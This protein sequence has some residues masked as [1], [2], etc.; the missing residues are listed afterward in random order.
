MEWQGIETA[1]RDGTPVETGKITPLNQTLGPLYPI[2]SKFMDGKWH[3][4]FGSKDQERW[5]PYDPQ[6]SHWKPLTPPKP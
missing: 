6:P 4:N 1:P 3:A 2:T 5:A